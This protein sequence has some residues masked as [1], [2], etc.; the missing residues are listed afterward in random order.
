MT[1]YFKN[2][3]PEATERIKTTWKGLRE[4]IKDF[5][6]RVNKFNPHHPL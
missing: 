1:K 4:V 2:R 6:K 3:G 5:Q